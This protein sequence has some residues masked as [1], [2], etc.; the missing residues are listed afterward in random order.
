MPSVSALVHKTRK[1]GCTLSVG[2]Q[3]VAS[4]L[5][6]EVVHDLFDYKVS[7]YIVE[8]SAIIVAIDVRPFSR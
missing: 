4:S 7:K 5:R 2:Q 3:F 6:D 8:S 1:Y